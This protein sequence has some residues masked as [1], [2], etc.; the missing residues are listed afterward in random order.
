MAS[1]P[2]ADTTQAEAPASQG[3]QDGFGAAFAEG[4]KAREA[5][6]SEPHQDGGKPSD[7][8]PA[9]AGSSEAPAKA[10]AD[11][12]TS[13]TA[14]K[15]DP[16]AGLTP[17]QMR[18]ELGK[19]STERDKL[20]QSDRSQRGRLGAL[21]RKYNDLEKQIAAAPKAAPAAAAEE[22]SQNDN[23]GGNADDEFAKALEDYP[24]VI[25]PLAKRMEELQAKIDKIGQPATTQSEID[26]DA[27]EMTLAYET[28]EGEH[29]DFAEIAND[30]SFT[31]W[32]NEQPDK[33]I[34]LANS[35]DPTEV[36]LALSKFKLQRSA[37]LATQSGEEGEPGRQEGTATD[38]RRQRQL[39]GSRAVTNRGA[40]A[41]AQVPND[42]SA[43]WKA[44][45]A[46]RAQ[47]AQG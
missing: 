25:G 11:A 42:F 30:P 9:P 29:P 3:E 6:A 20:Q 38:D 35:Y 19:L 43:A 32:L 27:E 40:P 39:E 12:G 21:T 16:W 7:P 5:A 45:A 1:Q 26:K 4:A 10:A 2:A 14:D 41:A 33:V 24:D 28:L 44:G 23:G 18:E 17:E 34:A 47:R 13:G 36:S 22:G 8:E 31:A 37:A 46:A 15:A